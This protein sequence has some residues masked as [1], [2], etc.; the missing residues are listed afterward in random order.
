MTFLMN[1]FYVYQLRL[2]NSEHPFYIG[3]GV[4]TRC[5][6]HL[7][8]FSLK[9]INRKNGII[10][11]AK[12][13]GIEV[14]VEKLHEN[15]A[16]N[17]ALEIEKTLIS[18]YG[19]LDKGTGI[20]ANM[21]DGGDGVRGNNGALN[22]MYGRKHREE[23][24]A[25]M[26]KSKVGRTQTDEHRAKNAAAKMGEQNSFFGKTHTEETRLLISQKRTGQAIHTEESRAKTSLRFKDKPKSSEHKEKI[27]AALKSKPIQQC[28]HCGTE[29]THNMSRYHFSNCRSL[30]S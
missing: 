21:T 30:H 27:R 13:K 11:S 8:Y 3:K 7:K 4:G 23:S 26:S 1:T 14:K 6:S 17:D 12:A 10:K 9:S 2:A 24:K 29:G 28:P 15:L 19:R 18:R 25:L 5:N 22:S 20:L 16:E